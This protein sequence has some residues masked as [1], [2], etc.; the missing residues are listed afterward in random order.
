MEE[1][2]LMQVDNTLPQTTDERAALELAHMKFGVPVEWKTRY[3]DDVLWVKR[4][5]ATRGLKFSPEHEYR[6]EQG[7]V[8]I[9]YRLKGVKL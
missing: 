5:E 2:N 1:S 8:G 6:V 3:S 4:G 9:N 7:Y